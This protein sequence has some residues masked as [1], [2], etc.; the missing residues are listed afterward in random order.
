MGGCIASHQH[1]GA[2]Q[3]FLVTSP[4]VQIIFGGVLALGALP[5]FLIQV[6]DL[7]AGDRNVGILP[8]ALIASIATAAVLLAFSITFLTWRHRVTVDEPTGAL[9]WRRHTLGLSWTSATWSREEIRAI[10]LEPVRGRYPAWRV[11]A[12]ADT[13]RRLL[14]ERIGGTEP[15]TV[16]REIAERLRQRLIRLGRVPG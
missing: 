3:T 1:A 10:E 12:R 7:L 6:G 15:K 9:M 11:M 2:S 16:A 13:R 4:V 5:P 14:Y 8:E